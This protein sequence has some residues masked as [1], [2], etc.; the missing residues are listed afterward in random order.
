MKTI[1]SSAILGVSMLLASASGG[2]FS[3]TP[4]A[5]SG[6][7]VIGMSSGAWI[8]F[9]NPYMG[10]MGLD[11]MPNPIDAKKV[12]GSAM[13]WDMGGKMKLELSV[14]GMPAGRA[15]GAHLHKLACA[16]MKA[17]GHYQNSMWPMGS[18]ANDPTYANR[19]NEA[20]LDFMTDGTGSKTVTTTVSWIP[21]AGE[22]KSIIVHHMGTAPGGVAGAKLACL[23][24]LFTN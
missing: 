13:A 16:E 7:K 15:F 11:G 1:H 12:S 18:N 2:C 24:V 10:M 6:G 3:D 22:A 19:D 4:D 8:V 5:A 14:A 20:W 17:G 21:R 23:P 9:D